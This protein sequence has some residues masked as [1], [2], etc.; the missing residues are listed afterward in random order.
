MDKKKMM[1]AELEGRLPVIYAI[2]MQDPDATVIS[3]PLYAHFDLKVIR[4]D[5]Q[6]EYI[7][8]KKRNI[9]SNIE[10]VMANKEKIN[11]NSTWGDDF[12]F[13]STFTDNI[14]LW[15]QPEKMPESGIT[16]GE[17]WIKKV[18]MD[19][20]SPKTLQKRLYYNVNDVSR[21]IRLPKITIDDN[22]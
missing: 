3:M 4:A 17:A 11:Y 12:Y 20:S 6:E 14:S 13:V 1:K 21:K 15:F 9:D 19:P 22:E 18:N 7:E 8:I 5:G 2:Q 16:E 10:T